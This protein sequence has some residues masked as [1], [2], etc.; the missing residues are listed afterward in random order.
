MAPEKKD[1]ENIHAHHRSR[2]RG[3]FLEYGLGFTDIQALELLL[4]Y[5]SPR[6]DTNVTAHLL[7]KKFHDFR[8][9]MEAGFEDLKQVEGIGESAAGLIALTAALNQ[10]YLSRRSRTGQK[11]DGTEAAAA[12]IRD[13]FAYEK[14]EKLLLLCLDVSSRVKYCDFLAKGTVNSVT[15]PLRSIVDTA[16]REN[17]SGIILAH[18]H[19]ADFALPSNADVEATGRLYKILRLL[20]IELID[21]FVVADGECVSMRDSGFLHQYM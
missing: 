8:G 18:N 1:G 5:A 12:F 17:A 3:Q 16:L 4:F 10:R 15:I 13:L 9:V 6:G 20:D 14:R 21:H 2:L 19:I 7:L 11:L